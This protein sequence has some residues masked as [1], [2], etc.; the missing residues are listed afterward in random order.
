MM[1]FY[2]AVLRKLRGMSH[3]R[4]WLLILLAATLSACGSGPPP[5]LYLLE[6]LSSDQEAR[7]AL[8]A[9]VFNSLGISLVELP[10]YVGDARITSVDKKGIVYHDDRH[11]WAEE[12]Q[13]AIS[14][15]LSDRLRIRTG[16][17]VLIEPWPRDYEPAARIEVI[18]AKLLREPLGGVEMAGQILLL[19]DDGRRLLKA[20]PFEFT[21]Y[22][23]DIK[24]RIFFDSVAQGVDDIARMIV[25]ALSELKLRS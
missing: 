8:E 15:V 23:R 16:A 12:P 18:F 17:T 7:G 2:T 22:G 24:K 3:R 13:D 1:S 6:S 10:G 19:S 20:L 5:K 9:P 4:Q 25:Q 21:L 14:R 11:R